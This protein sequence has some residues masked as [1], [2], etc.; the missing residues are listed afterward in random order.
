MVAI[1][2]QWLMVLGLSPIVFGGSPQAARGGGTP[3]GIPCYESKF[4]NA[5]QALITAGK[6]PPAKNLD[7]AEHAAWT[8]LAN[9]LL[10]LDETL[11]RE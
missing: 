3:L 10:N 4:S 5:A 8:G 9:I 2:L 11:T 6:Y 7:P 1:V